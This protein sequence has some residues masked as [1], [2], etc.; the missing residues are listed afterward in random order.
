MSSVPCPEGDGVCAIPEHALVVTEGKAEV[1]SRDE[2]DAEYPDLDLEGTLERPK[3]P[4][5]CERPIG[6]SRIPTNCVTSSDLSQLRIQASPLPMRSRALLSRS[7]PRLRIRRCTCIARLVSTSSRRRCHERQRQ[8]TDTVDLLRANRCRQLSGGDDRGAGC[9]DS[10]ADKVVTAAFSVATAYGAVIV[11]I[12][13]KDSQTPWQAVIPF[14]PLALAMGLALYAQSDWDRDR[15]D[16]RCGD[17]PDARSKHELAGK[18]KRGRWSLAALVAALLAAGWVVYWFYGPS[19]KADEP[20]LVDAELGSDAC[21]HCR[22]ETC[23]RE[24]RGDRLER[25]G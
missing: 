2:I 19:A 4:K 10:V 7:S 1:W 22:S 6:R 3:T 15:R 23:L 13:P 16:G 17:R 9:R 5:R 11:L 12:A 24:G 18:R 25:T 21:R 8:R 14:V 20:S